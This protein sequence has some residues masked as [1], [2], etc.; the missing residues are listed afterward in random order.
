MLGCTCQPTW[1]CMP[2]ATTPSP[3]G[4]WR[5]STARTSSRSVLAGPPTLGPFPF[6]GP[7]W[8]AVV[9]D[10]NG[11]GLTTLGVVDPGT[12]TW[13]LRNENSAGNAD[14]ATPFQFGLP[15]WI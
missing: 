8:F 3:S 4:C 1:E 13:Y 11:D 6:G 15:G 7:G 2:T 5:G 9:G 12:M 10:W 14:A